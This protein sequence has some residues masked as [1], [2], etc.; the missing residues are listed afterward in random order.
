MVGGIFVLLKATRH[1]LPSSYEVPLLMTP[2]TPKSM[3]RIRSVTTNIFGGSS[4]QAAVDG[5]VIVQEDDKVEERLTLQQ[6]QMKRQEE[7]LKQAAAELAAEKEQLAKER[8]EFEQQKMDLDLKDRIIGFNK[9]PSQNIAAAA[10]AG[11]KNA[12][13]R[14]NVVKDESEEEEN[15]EEEEN[16]EPQKQRQPQKSQIDNNRQQNMDPPQ[17]SVVCGG[18][19]AASCDRCP[20]GHGEAWCHGDCSWC[21]DTKKCISKGSFC[22]TCTTKAAHNEAM[23]KA[24]PVSEHCHWCD[25]ATQCLHVD[26]FCPTERIWKAPHKEKWFTPPDPI[27]KY[28]RTLSVVLPCGS[29]NDFFERTIRSIYAATPPEILKDI[30]VVDDNSVPP[31]EPMFSLDKNEYKVNFIRSNVSLGLIDAKHQGA[32]AATGDIIVFFDCHVKPA[33]GYWEPFVREIA[34]NPKR[35]VVPSITHLDVDLWKESG[36]P[37]DNLGGNSKCY[38]TMDSDFKWVANNK[39]WVPTMSGGLLAIGRDWFFEIGGHDQ[40]MKVRLGL[41][42]YVVS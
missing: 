13:I 21:A 3:D 33:I 40:N 39:P 36:R 32:M 24:L 10:A 27:D 4:H 8:L 17:K 7:R 11:A 12:N 20:Q 28:N 26:S 2:E 31:L 42:L 29:E 14:P 25:I 16:D 30:I 9:K 41:T 37:P 23:C 19:K 6:K 18:H 22:P 34:E 1:H 15:P 5:T 35:V 38:T